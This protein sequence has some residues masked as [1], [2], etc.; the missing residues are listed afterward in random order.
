MPLPMPSKCYLPCPAQSLNRI[1]ISFPSSF[2]SYH[3][4]VVLP[5]ATQQEQARLS[6]ELASLLPT[7]PPPL[8]L[9]RYAYPTSPHP[10]SLLASRPCPVP[11]VRARRSVFLLRLACRF[12]I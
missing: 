9:P 1:F 12:C 8:S 10:L 5:P 6:P 11:V 3:P 7:Q 4:V 2:P